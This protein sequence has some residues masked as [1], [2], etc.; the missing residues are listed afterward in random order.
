M[1][2]TKRVTRL[3]RRAP[4]LAIF[5]SVSMPLAN[6]RELWIIGCGPM[7]PTWITPI[8]RMPMVIS[9]P[10]P[11]APPPKSAVICIVGMELVKQLGGP[12]GVSWRGRVIVESVADAQ[13]LHTSPRGVVLVDGV[14]DCDLSCR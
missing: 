7:D 9:I 11:G 5:G 14:S 3:G 12:I 10:E 8:G 1:R 2:Y 4:H 6:P 13:V